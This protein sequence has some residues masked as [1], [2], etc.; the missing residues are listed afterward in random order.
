MVFCHISLASPGSRPQKLTAA[1]VKTGRRSKSLQ[2]EPRADR[3]QTG[4]DPKHCLLGT[5]VSR[6]ARVREGRDPRGM[7]GTI[8]SREPRSSQVGS[9]GGCAILGPEVRPRR[10]RAQAGSARAPGW[11]RPRG[12]RRPPLAQAPPF[13]TCLPPRG[14]A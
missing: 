12:S 14:G 6:E 4:A 2:P 11:L 9:R 3:K 8:V 7:P 5:V 10:A 1:P 13:P